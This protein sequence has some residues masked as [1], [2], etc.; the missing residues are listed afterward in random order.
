MRI[1]SF[2]VVVVLLALSGRSVNAD[3][4]TFTDRA[5]WEAAV[6]G[7]ITTEDF[8]GVS[9]FELPSNGTTAVGLLTIETTNSDLRQINDGTDSRNIDGSNFFKV[10]TDNDPVR[11]AAILFSSPVLAWAVDYN[12]FNDPTF[13]TFASIVEGSIGPQNSS[14]FAG[15]VSDT[16]FSR[17]DLISTNPSFAVIGLDNVSFVAIPEPSAFVCMGLVSLVAG[18]RR[19]TRKLRTDG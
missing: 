19:L 15:Y 13:V 18:G 8:N 4:V 7:S 16:A 10:R 12:Q 17:V 9:P 5:A 6:S 11:S 3:V 1:Q 2:L 14:G